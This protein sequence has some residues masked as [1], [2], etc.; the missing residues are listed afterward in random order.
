M[1]HHGFYGERFAIC[2]NRTDITDCP[3]QILTVQACWEAMFEEKFKKWTFL[4][5]LV[6]VQDSS[7]K[8]THQPRTLFGRERV[9]TGTLLESVI[10][11]HEELKGGRPKSS[12]LK[13]SKESRMSCTLLCSRERSARGSGTHTTCIPAAHP[14]S[15]PLGA[16]SNTRT[17]GKRNEVPSILRVPS[18]SWRLLSSV[19][20]VGFVI[21]S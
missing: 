20:S 15:T 13:C 5:D 21:S 3:T 8:R 19:K 1:W 14:A 9:K 2:Q 11:H 4:V 10:H 16:S 12:G 7:W 18:N 17:W 6:C